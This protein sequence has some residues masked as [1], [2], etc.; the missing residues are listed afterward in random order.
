MGNIGE[1]N[2]AEADDATYVE[3]GIRKGKP[4]IVTYFVVAATH[5][6]IDATSGGDIHGTIYGKK[7]V[8]RW[9]LPAD[10]R[11]FNPDTLRQYL[12][13]NMMIN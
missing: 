7:Q 8:F 12:L 6:I 2:I 9:T 5:G 3:M 1:F 4:E 13:S 11:E 10:R